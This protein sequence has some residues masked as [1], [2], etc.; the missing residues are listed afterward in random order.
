[1]STRKVEAAFGASLRAFRVQLGLSQADLAAKLGV[2]QGAV[3]QLERGESQPS[4]LLLVAL[5]AV[6]GVEWDGRSGFRQRAKSAALLEAE[7]R[8]WEAALEP[9]LIGSPLEGSLPQLAMGTGVARDRAR[10]ELAED[11]KREIQDVLRRFAS[12]AVVI[13]KTLPPPIAEKMNDE[14]AAHVVEYLEQAF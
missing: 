5:R 10:R 13:D 7:P 6:F 14:L 12:V 11:R 8:T 1:M 4:G 3:G 9:F 2:T